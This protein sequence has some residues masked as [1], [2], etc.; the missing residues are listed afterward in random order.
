MTLLSDYHYF[1]FFLFLMKRGPP[2]SN[3]FRRTTL[4]RS[5]LDSRPTRPRL[6]VFVG[7]QHRL[8]PRRIDAILAAL[9]GVEVVSHDGRQ[10]RQNSLARQGMAQAHEI[11]EPH[12]AEL[13]RHAILIAHRAVHPEAIVL[14]VPQFG[15]E[16][17]RGFLQRSPPFF[18]LRALAGRMGEPEM[19][20]A[21]QRR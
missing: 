6:I 15:F 12:A 21:L 7:G 2:S 16:C 14:A 13:I 17:A 1:R 4:F 10:R 8:A 19:A 18:S 5:I 9:L 11:G 20:A 3:P